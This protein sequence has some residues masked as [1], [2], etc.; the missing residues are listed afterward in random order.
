MPQN[1]VSTKMTAGRV[2][3]IPEGM[4]VAE[5]LQTLGG[6]SDQ[7]ISEAAEEKPEPVG[8]GT[9]LCLYRPP[10]K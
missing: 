5:A 8:V 7:L 10:V 9:L 6:Y 1:G 2:I 3:G 4:T